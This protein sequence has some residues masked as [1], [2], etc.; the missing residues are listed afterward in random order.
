M[1]LSNHIQLECA[2]GESGLHWRYGFG[3]MSIYA[4]KAKLDEVV[5]WE[6]PERK[7]FGHPT[8]VQFVSPYQLAPGEK[9]PE[10]SLH[11]RKVGGDRLNVCRH[12]LAV[13]TL[14]EGGMPCEGLLFLDWCLPRC[15]S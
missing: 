7:V 3:P 10:C 2:K 12:L 14:N 15:C 5:V 1:F 8:S 13:E 6:I 11:R 9:F 4:L